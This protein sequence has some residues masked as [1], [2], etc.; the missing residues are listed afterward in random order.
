MITYYTRPVDA[1]C[2]RQNVWVKDGVIV[3][4]YLVARSGYYTGPGNPE[5]VGQPESQLRKLGFEPVAGP[6]V[7]DSLTHSWVSI[8]L[9][10]EYEA[11]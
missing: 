9:D 7:F 8:K 5:L 2:G 1:N 10:E 6:Q 4:Q 3:K 11:D